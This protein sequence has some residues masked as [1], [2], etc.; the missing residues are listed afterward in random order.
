MNI[1]ISLPITGQDIEMVEAR[2]E[3]AAGAIEGLGHKPVNPL[4][5]GEGEGK[6]YGEYL[7][8]DIAAIIDRCDAVV[9]LDGWESSRGCMLEFSAAKI[10]HKIVFMN[11]NSIPPF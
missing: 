5:F 10:Y 8:K 4:E 7:G 1:Y 2:A 11:L 3:F 9:F 6:S